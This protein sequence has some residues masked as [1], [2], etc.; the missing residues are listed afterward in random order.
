MSGKVTPDIR[1]M[2]VK[3]AGNCC[4]YCRLSQDDA[5]Y[6]FHIEHIIARKH[7]GT[8]D[9]DNL[10]LSCQHCNVHMGTDLGGIDNITNT[11]T[12]LFHPRRDKWDEHFRLIES[13]VEGITATGRV[14]VFLLNMNSQQQLSKR[15][16]LRTL[17]R[18][19]C[20]ISPS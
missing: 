6:R 20:A 15:E 19:P 1:R 7:R 9:L 16:A 10:C 11:F 12:F 18:Y 4:E 3:R 14:T 2:V 17:N 5:F 8:D 13:F